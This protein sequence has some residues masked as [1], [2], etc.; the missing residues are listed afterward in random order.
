MVLTRKQ[1]ISFYRNKKKVAE[2]IIDHVKKKKQ[3]IFG[4]RSLNAHFPTFL[5]KPTIDYDILIEKGNPKKVAKRLEKKLDKKFKGNFFVVEKA[6]HPG[7]YKVKRIL[8][9]EGII[10]IS[11][12][13]EKVPTD[14]IKGVRFSKLSFEKGKIKQSLRDPQSKFR[15]EKDK[16]RLERIRIFESLKKKKIRKPRIRKRIVTLPIH[17][18]LKTRT[19]F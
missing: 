12:S 13:K 6:R 14:K 11:K 9:K 4:A 5:D 8:G 19:N 10:D 15:H 16:E 7:T 1:K 3:I 2:V 17:F 18:K